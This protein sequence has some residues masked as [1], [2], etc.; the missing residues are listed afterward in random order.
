MNTFSINLPNINRAIVISCSLLGYI[1]N[2]IWL[3]LNIN[4]IIVVIAL[5][6]HTQIRNPIGKTDLLRTEI[7]WC[8]QTRKT[9][10]FYTLQ[11]NRI[12]F[13]FFFHF[14][15]GQH[16]VCHNLI[17]LILFVWSAGSSSKLQTI[18]S[19][20]SNLSMRCLWWY[21]T[22]MDTVSCEIAKSSPDDDLLSDT[23]VRTTRWNLRN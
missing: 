3:Q 15:I 9:C 17:I 10:F 4:I 1:I 16:F 18:N 14:C 13:F 19:W 11:S 5:A 12:L 8:D 6:K 20:M 7:A 2:I 23:C 21:D 22:W